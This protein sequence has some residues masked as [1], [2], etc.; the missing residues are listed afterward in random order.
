MT[1]HMT[2][3]IL[4]HLPRG[5]ESASTNADF[6]L[7]DDSIDCVLTKRKRFDF[8]LILITTLIMGTNGND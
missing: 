5:N 7:L 6:H 4:I 2:K 8:I 1:A 3:P